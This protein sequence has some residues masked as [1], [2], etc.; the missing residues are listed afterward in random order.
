MLLHDDTGELIK[1]I[2]INKTNLKTSSYI[3]LVDSMKKIFKDNKEIIND[4]K[5]IYKIASSTN[6]LLGISSSCVT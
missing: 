5:E 2:I 6:F 1:Q 3:L 4:I